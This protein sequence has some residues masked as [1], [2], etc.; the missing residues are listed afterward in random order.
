MVAAREDEIKHFKPQTYYGIEAQTNDKLKLTW[1]DA[2][3]NSRSF[4]KD[5]IDTIVKKVSNDNAKVVEIERKPKNICSWP[6]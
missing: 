3:G 2:K 6:I 4:D 1:Q 5:K